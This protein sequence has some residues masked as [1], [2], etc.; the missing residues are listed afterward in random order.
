MLCLFT[1]RRCPLGHEPECVRPA[2]TLGST[3][4]NRSY[5]SEVSNS[6]SNERE[7]LPFLLIHSAV[8]ARQSKYSTQSKY[9]FRK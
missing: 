4:T 6:V 7:R 2:A 5:S 8:A 3:L 1:L 9:L